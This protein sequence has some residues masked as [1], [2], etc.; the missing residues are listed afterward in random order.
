MDTVTLT[1][2]HGIHVT[3]NPLGACWTSCV[4]PLSGGPREILLGSSDLATM[5]AGSSYLGA[6]V[7]RYAGRIANARFA[8]HALATNQFPHILHGGPEGF[9]RQR[10][11]PGPSP[12]L[13]E[14]LP[15]T[16]QTLRLHLHSAD[17][18][19]G[20]PGNLD[21]EVIYQ[22][23]DDDS[24]TITYLARTDAPTPC[25]ITS[26]A[27]FNLNGGDGDDGLNQW[28]QIH[29]SRYQPVGADGIPDAPPH[30]VDGTGFD[31]R[32]GKRI[33]TD[34]L[35]DADQ[36]KVH[37]YDHSFLLD[38]DSDTAVR[39][40]Q[41]VTLNRAAELHAADDRARLAIWTNQPALH[42]YTGQHLAGT[43]KRDGSA[44]ASHAGIALE[45][46]Y[47]PDSPSHGQAILQPG[48]LYR[49]VIRCEFDYA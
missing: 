13:A 4:L 1:N 12:A 29:A 33:G 23:A 48:E 45:S 30:P 15:A 18:D 20:F 11:Q 2:R 21:V 14:V 24:L 19:Q 42:L 7:G 46:Q 38:D 41:G 40:D 3:L 43:P 27:Y 25:N 31:F 10:W 22:L 35:R 17:D 36:Q 26:H 32:T 39:T 44:Y 49:H 6:S 8:G 16:G 9:S 34:I 37:G 28:L 47:P 5:L